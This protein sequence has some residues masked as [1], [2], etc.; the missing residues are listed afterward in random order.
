MRHIFLDES[1][2]LGFDFTR[3]R[4]S[5]FFLVACLLTDQ[6]RPIEKL[7]RKTHSNLRKKSNMRDGTLHA[8][9]EEPGVINYFCREL[10][11]KRCRLATIIFDKTKIPFPLRKEKHALYTHVIAVLLARLLHRGL[12]SKNEK[13]RLVV[14]KRET[15]KFLNRSFHEEL[16]LCLQ[17]DHAMNL[18][19]AIKTPAEAKCLQAAD[20]VSWSLFR[21]YEYGDEKYYVLLQPIITEEHALI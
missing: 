17:N 16:R 6:P 14:S 18:T 10:G 20:I 5:T 19:V 13:I 21:K 2:D 3:K 4:T 15:N 7:V 1:G 9:K 11:K 8:S 12:V